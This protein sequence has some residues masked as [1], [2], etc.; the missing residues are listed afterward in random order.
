MDKKHLII[1]L[2]ILVIGGIFAV[3]VVVTPFFLYPSSDESINWARARTTLSAV[4]IPIV[5]FGFYFT[6]IQFRKSL[7]KPRIKVVFNEKG[8]QQAIVE[9]TDENRGALPHPFMINEGTAV[10]RFFQIV[11]TIPKNIGNYRARDYL[12]DARYV[13]LDDFDTDNYVFT[14]TNDGRYTL[15]VKKPYSD[16]VFSLESVLDYKKCIELF[17]TGFT[18]KYEIYGDWGEPQKGELKVILKKQ[19]ALHAH[20]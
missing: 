7:A 16:P 8:E 18:L 11:V 3:A 4:T 20:T 17:N 6:T 19:E 1:S 13:S 14:Y 2:C 12:A 9:Y 10:A 15:F 5:I